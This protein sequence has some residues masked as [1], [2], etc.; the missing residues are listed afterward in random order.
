MGAFSA[1]RV[2]Q[3]AP[4]RLTVAFKL[5]RVRPDSPDL[6]TD[7]ALIHAVDQKHRTSPSA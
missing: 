2:Q 1:T 6:P 5:A 4:I 7:D 3:D